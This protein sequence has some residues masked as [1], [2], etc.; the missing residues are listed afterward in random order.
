MKL[1]RI[2]AYALLSAALILTVSC[3]H[4]PTEARPGLTF[5]GVASWYGPDF[6]GKRTASGEVY[7]MDAMTCAHKTLPFGTRLRVTN[8]DNDR[9]VV[10]VV[11]DRGPFVRGRDIDLSRA[12][13][14][15]I[16]V[17]LGE[18]EMEVLGRDTRYVKYVHTG[19]VSGTGSFR[20]QV[21]SFIDPWNAE[22][23][24]QGLELNYESVTVTRAVVDGRTFNRVQVG[25]F[26]D[27]DDAYD[28]AEALA[29]EGYDTLIVRE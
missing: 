18:V 20:V 3:A 22:H 28:T 29:D 4:A 17:S 10:V 21:G 27:K 1:L 19:R 2:P 11:N 15:A 7:D 14:R 5:S 13:A 6:H 12:A 16:G 26:P 24:K 8:P 23:L 25:R 9:S